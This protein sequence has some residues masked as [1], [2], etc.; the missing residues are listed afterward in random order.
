[1]PILL[2]L[3]LLLRLLRL[4]VAVVVDGVL[5]LIS[6]KLRVGIIEFIVEFAIGILLLD[7]IEEVIAVLVAATSGGRR[8]LI[9]PK[10]VLMS[11]LPLPLPI[12]AIPIP[13][14]LVRILLVVLQQLLLI[15]SLLWL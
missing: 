3:L 9:A 12:S 7:N 1:M 14:G 8:L 2:L 6:G 5:L 11:R 13:G 4:L 15:K 10:D